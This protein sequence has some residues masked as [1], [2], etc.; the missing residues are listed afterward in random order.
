MIGLRSTSEQ[1][2]VF[3]LGTRL[4]YSLTVISNQI[5]ANRINPVQ[6]RR[7]HVAQTDAHEG[8]FETRKGDATRPHLLLHLFSPMSSLS[9]VDASH[10]FS[11]SCRLTL[12]VSLKCL[13]PF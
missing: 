6:Q 9:I 5:E 3:V 11:N 7:P 8:R 1:A 12:A 10:D 13:V 2:V 4:P